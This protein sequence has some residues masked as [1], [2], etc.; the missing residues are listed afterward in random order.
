MSIEAIQTALKSIKYPGFSRDIVSFGIVRDVLFSQ[1]KAT[2]ALSIT[3]NNPSIPEA[4]EAAVTKTLQ[5]LPEVQEV[6]I[7]LDV[8]EHKQPLTAS[9]DKAAVPSTLS[10]IKHIIAIASGKGG[11]GKSTTSVNLACAL[12][13]ILSNQGKKNAVG[14]L[15]CDI[16]G[17]SI[18]LMLGI[19]Q[20]PYIENDLIL[21]LENFG[22]RTMSMGFLIDED[23]PVVWRGPMI[24][25]TIQQFATQVKWGELE[26][27]II[28]LPPGTGDTQLSVVQTFPIEG[29]V[30]VTTP[31]T[32]AVNVARRGAMMFGK[33]NV[34]LYGVIENMSSIT[35]SLT[36]KKEAIF[37]EGGGLKAAQALQTD[38]L[39]QIPLD[40]NIRIG[41]DRG[42]PIVVSDPDAPAA[43]AFHTIAKALLQKCKTYQATKL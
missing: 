22:V 10:G 14:V 37:G 43:Q 35:D 11:V 16:Y 20:R 21:P 2:V 24:M 15:D 19:N 34:P 17:P 6:I 28:D 39:G 27:L 30:I 3:T 13:K 18:P 29:A 25:K 41:S 26:V 33:V 42:I 4:I 8:H 5:S 32:A 1:G 7:N 38:L 36:G 12:D 9:K 31:Q 40:T 23:A